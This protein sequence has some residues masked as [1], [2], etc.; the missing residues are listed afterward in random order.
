MG[1]GWSWTKIIEA[2]IRVCYNSN[3]YV[4][5]RKNFSI[6]LKNLRNG[7]GQDLSIDKRLTLFELIC[8]V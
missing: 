3:S 6:F 1:R 5:E 7:K 2:W 4:K 8:G